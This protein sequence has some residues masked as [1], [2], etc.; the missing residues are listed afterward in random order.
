[1]L[2][3]SHVRFYHMTH[4][5]LVSWASWFFYFP[6]EENLYS[7][8]SCLESQFFP[9]F[10]S[11]TNFGM[12]CL[13]YLNCLNQ[14]LEQNSLLSFCRAISRVFCRVSFVQNQFLLFIKY[15]ENL[16]WLLKFTLRVTL[17]K[18]FNFP[19]K[20]LRKNTGA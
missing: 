3:N 11:R 8:P 13:V 17:V 2:I 15:S 7:Q 18:I 14:N 6:R 1:M 10:L 12:D 20:K 9:S 5:V 16:F 19:A 4:R